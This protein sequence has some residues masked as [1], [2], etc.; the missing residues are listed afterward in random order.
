LKDNEIF[1]NC[2]EDDDQ[3]DGKEGSGGKIAVSDEELYRKVQ[4]GGETERGEKDVAEGK[5]LDD[6]HAEGY[7]QEDA[8]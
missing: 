2:K 3:K 1:K 5:A 6:C 7:Q 4:T 8:Q